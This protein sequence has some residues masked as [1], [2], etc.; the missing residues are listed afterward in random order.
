MSENEIGKPIRE[1]FDTLHKETPPPFEEAW[2]AAELKHRQS[3]RRYA[4]F[5][6]IAAAL[7]IVVVGLLSLKQADLNDEFLIADSLLN[8]TQW[9]APSDVLLP[10]HQYDIYREVPFLVE[11]MNIDEGLFL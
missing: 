6:G 11:P 5:S 10:Q 8:K 3:R 1:A 7:A 2:S 9:S 4:T